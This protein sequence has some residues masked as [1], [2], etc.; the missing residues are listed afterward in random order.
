MERTL[1]NEIS[2]KPG[3]KVLIKG[4]A[5][6]VRKLGGLSFVV[7]QDRSGSIQVVFEK[8]SGIKVGD[9]VEIT[10]E[11][12]K[13]E[14]AKG[15]FEIAGK[16]VEVVANNIEDLPFDLARNELNLTVDNLYDFRPLSLRHPK[17]QA[18]SSIHLSNNNFC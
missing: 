1:I 7:V 12:K 2:G 3:E 16:K 10:G 5:M 17:I 8:D 14:R 11:V 6:V 4:R 18:S 15:S 9:A 13:D